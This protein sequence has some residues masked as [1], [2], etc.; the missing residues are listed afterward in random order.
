VA[1][2]AHVRTSVGGEIDRRFR[3]RRIGSVRCMAPTAHLAARRLGRQGEAR[4]GHVPLVDRVTRR[5]LHLRVS[6]QG[7][8]RSMRPWQPPQLSGVFGGTGSCASWQERHFLRGLCC[9][10]SDLREPVGTRRVVGVAAQARTP[11][12]AAAGASVR[13]RRPAC[14]EDGPWQFSQLMLRCAPP[15]FSWN[16]SSWHSRQA[17]TPACRTGLA[18]SRATAASWCG[19]AE[20]IEGGSTTRRSNSTTATMAAMTKPRARDLLR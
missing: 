19:F 1:L 16:C 13:S 12:R 18:I 2:P 5:A 6:R 7:L 14:A 17:A 15:Y 20:N 4:L 11:A 3:G 10:G 9:C 8:V